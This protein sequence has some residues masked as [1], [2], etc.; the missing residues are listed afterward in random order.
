[1]GGF[2]RELLK[3]H[4]IGTDRGPSGPG[5]MDAIGRWPPGTLNDDR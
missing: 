4:D 2:R 5:V 3:R 1:V